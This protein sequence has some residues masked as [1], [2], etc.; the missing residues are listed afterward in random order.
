M[1]LLL[2]TGGFI[3]S[4]KFILS[5]QR[6]HYSANHNHLLV[7]W[8]IT[9]L[10]GEDTRKCPTDRYSICIRCQLISSIA[11]ESLIVQVS[12][13]FISPGGTLDAATEPQ[14]T[15]QLR[16]QS[17]EVHIYETVAERERRSKL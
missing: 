3:S 14:N 2:F 12:L 7:K 6:S 11:G 5:R 16:R 9:S 15:I 13:Y 4:T 10:F 17:A 8:L 1:G